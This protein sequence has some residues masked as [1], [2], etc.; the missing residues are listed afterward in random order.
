ML[1]LVGLVL[2]V[3][4]VLRDRDQPTP[5][6]TVGGVTLEVVDPRGGEVDVSGAVD[7][8]PGPKPGW[9]VLG[10]SVVFEIDADA[11]TTVDPLRLHFTIPNSTGELPGIFWNARLLNACERPRPGGYP[12]VLTDMRQDPRRVTVIATRVETQLPPA[13]R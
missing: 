9:L 6:V 1:A 8:V 5:I 3:V 4:V 13:L 2:A 11:G 12:C 7:G 10:K